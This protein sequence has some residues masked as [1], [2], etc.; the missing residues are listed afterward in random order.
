MANDDD[1]RTII[2]NRTGVTIAD[3]GPAV[4]LEDFDVANIDIEINGAIA[5]FSQD[6]PREIL[7]DHVP[8]DLTVIN[9]VSFFLLNSW[10]FDLSGEEE[11]EIEHPVDLAPPAL[12]RRNDDLDFILVSK[13]TGIGNIEEK[14]ITFLTV[15]SGSPGTWRLRYTTNWVD[16][17]TDAVLAGLTSRGVQMVGLLA[18]AYVARA[19]AGRFAKTTN[20]NVDADVV[21]YRS[22]SQ[23]FRDIAQT[24]FEEYVDRLDRPSRLKRAGA[25]SGKCIL[26]LVFQVLY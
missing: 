23:E 17:V 15:P 25:E 3:P 12:F 8:G 21:D 13:P 20:T 24:L 19:L 7:E 1:V 11:V 2:K 10:N 14:W 4:G 18:A 5:D 6:E 9:G 16:L 22:K 26:I